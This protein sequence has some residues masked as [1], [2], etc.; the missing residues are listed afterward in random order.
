MG[1]LDRAT[2]MVAVGLAV[3]LAIAVALR[4]YGLQ[5]D[6]GYS[7]TP[8]PDE[9]AILMN[10]ADLSPPT[11]GELGLLLDP[12]ESPWNPGWFPYGSFPLYL[13]KGVQ[14]V[15]EMWPGAELHDLRVAGRAISAAADVGTVLFVYLLGSR[16]HGRRE[17][18]LAS[19]LTALAVLHIQLSHFYAVDTLLG[20]LTIAA[21]YF[22]YRVAREGR[23][24]DSLLAGAFVGLGLAT[25]VSQAPVYIAFV[26]AWLLYISASGQSGPEPVSLDLR[27]RAAVKG[28]AVGLGASVA[29]FLFVQPYALLDWSQFYS[30]VTEQSEMVRR[31]RDYPYTRQ[32]V[33]TAPY[34]YHIRQLATWGLG[35]P[36]GIVA[37]AGL[38]Y[39]SLRGSRLRYGLAYLAVGWG[40]PAGLLLF[41]TSFPFIIL[42]FAIAFAGMLAY[43]PFRSEGSRGDLLLLAWVAPY[44]LVTGAL[45]VKFLR[46]LLPVTPF[47]LLFG[48]RMLFALWDRVVP[49]RP[50]LRP[51]LAAGL[52]LLVG[53]TALYALAYTSIYREPHTAVRTSQWLNRSAPEGSLILKEH[54]EEGLPDLHR[55]EVQELPLYEDDTPRKLSQIA[56]MLSEADY[57]TFYS[58]RLYGTIP[59]LPERYPLTTG[60]Y[61]LLFSGDLGYELVNAESAYPQLAG[62][63]LA[64]DSFGR[65][66]LRQPAELATFEPSGLKLNL[67]FADESFSVYDHPL[68][69]VFEN[70]ARHG[71][72]AIERVIR[73]ASEGGAGRPI[74]AADRGV[75]LLMSPEDAAAQP[76]GGTWTD[77]VRPG[78]WTN[79][80]PILAWL[81][82]L[83]GVALIAWPVSFLAFRPLADRGYLFSKALGLLAL[84]L[85]VWLMASLHW[86]AFSAGSIIVGVV[87]LSAVSFVTLARHRQEIAAFV[88]SHWRLLA[89]E[90]AI[91]LIA[92]L[93]FV[94]VRMANPDLWHPFLGG[95]KPMDHAYL[96]AVVR[97]S[98]MPPYDPWFAGGYIN[99]YYWGQFVVATLVKATGIDTRV[100]FNLAVPMFFALTAGGAFSLV[101]DLAESTRR[102]LAANAADR[103]RAW[104][105]VVGGLAGAVFVTV[106]GNLDGAIQIGEGVWRAWVRNL[107]FGTFD[108]WRSSRM[109]PPGNEIT[110][111]PFF[112]FLF[113]DLHAHLMAL[114]FTVLALGL[115]LAVVLGARSS[116]WAGEMARLAVLGVVVGALRLI[117]TWDFPTYLMVAAAAVFLAGYLRHGGLGL[118]NLLESGV[119]SLLVFLVGYV[120]F[121]P[122]HLSY[123]TFFSSVE[124]T[125]NQTVLWRYL[126][127]HGLFIFVIGSF[128]LHQSRGWLSH[129][130]RLLWHKVE[131]LARV[132][133]EAG[134]PG[135]DPREATRIAGLRVTALLLA[136]LS[137]GF[138]IFMVVSGWLG[139]A[140]PFLASMLALVLV[141]A[142]GFLR[143][144]RADAAHLSFVAVLVGVP[145]A[146]AIGLDVYRVEGD[147]N[148]MNSVFKFYLQIWVM[149]ALVSA[150]LLW[151]L[152]QGRQAGFGSRLGQKLWLAGLA[153]L[154]VGTAIYPVLG[155]R[156]RL[157]SRFEVTPATLDGMAFMQGAEY[158]DEHGP[159]QLAHDYEGVRWLQQN[160][161]GSPVVLEGWTDQYRWGGRISVYTGLP[162]I[163]GWKW[164]QEQ[165]RWGYRDKVGERVEDVDRIY[166]TPDA[167]VALELLRKY[168]VEYVYVGQL[169]RLYYP[170]EGIRKFDGELAPELQ[171]VHHTD[172]VSIYR[173][174]EG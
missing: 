65:S 59:R 153:A 152:W 64:H 116:T 93:G 76:E 131:G 137:F 39:V 38:A 4:F 157:K 24:R 166:S 27:V 1:S 161:D 169:E 69:L 19:A 30:D 80:L 23:V 67:G 81:I 145:M 171:R 167:S 78:G 92:F 41:S 99:Y 133:A 98:Y 163:V 51:L 101:Y 160:V 97:S 40:V 21:L 146:L 129:L 13:L 107:P 66:G 37:W 83:E 147:I 158:R 47:L 91:F 44:L 89:I 34:W 173:L 52:V 56:A 20:L 159:I 42:A 134:L 68:G 12:E 9:R 7:H 90:D 14:L 164:H 72:S 63:S 35:W 138:V 119:K 86:V 132:S 75:G 74:A 168:G 165:Q 126:A 128:F 142:V 102:R 95:E 112:T 77:I 149:L 45:D 36:L 104:S 100:A 143:S 109:M 96:N 62:V 82:V 2:V 172:E 162:S 130:A 155:T 156:E 105:P 113:A 60:Y 114:P 103:G 25:K 11:L 31:I 150:Y 144:P 55:Y 135:I 70:T 17:A 170:S 121:L 120:V 125:T 50:R 118:S 26:M 151:H 106:L 10:V 123:E 108:F 79:R 141:A 73:D 84:A 94:L 57:V 28:L 22:M 124:S 148:R 117:N 115:A 58:N 110:E 5:W 33:D 136:G 6:R 54:W 122:Y 154:L 111:F 29:V 88:R 61:S 16:L 32:Y 139:S 18:L 48:S 46:Y 87:I 8:H 3:V 15:Y 85:A 140:I 127:I 71:A 53:I 49:G 174:R 43:V